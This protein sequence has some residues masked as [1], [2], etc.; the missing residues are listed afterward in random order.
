MFK[1]KIKKYYQI[2]KAKCKK[3]SVMHEYKKFN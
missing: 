2:K 1:L 3:I